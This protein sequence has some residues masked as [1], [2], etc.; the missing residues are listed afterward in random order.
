MSENVSRRSF[1]GLMGMGMMGAVAANTIMATQANASGGEALQLRDADSSAWDNILKNR[2]P[3]KDFA[4]Q[5]ELEDPSEYWGENVAAPHTTRESAYGNILP[6]MADVPRSDVLDMVLDE[7][8]LEEIEDVVL[9][10]GTVVPKVYVKLRNHINRIGSGIGSTPGPTSYQMLMY[11]WSEEDAQHEIEMPILTY[12]DANEYHHSSGRP[13][14]ECKEILEDMAN[15]NLIMKANHSGHMVYHLL[16]HINGFWEFNELRA[17]FQNGGNNKIPEGEDALKAA[18]MFDMQGIGGKDPG[19]SFNIEVP[20][21]HTYPVSV[22]VV[23]ED[24]L[25]PFMDW[26]R[27]IEENEKITVSPC[28]CRLMWASFGLPMCNG[29]DIAETEEGHPFETCLSFGELAEYFAETGIGR[30]ITQEEAIALYEEGMRR[31]MV[32]ESLSMKD[33]DIMCMCH[34]DCCGNLSGWK[35]QRGAGYSNININA[36]LLKY[37]P[38]KCIQCGACIERCPMQAISFD[39]DGYCLHN[40]TCVRCGQCV[41]VCPVDARI[42][43]YRGDFPEMGRDYVDAVETIAIDRMRRGMIKDFPGG[44]IE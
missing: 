2:D 27:I 10:D 22:D 7:L 30:Y 33:V 21:F 15:R 41:T 18:A 5:F 6:E 3:E 44:A 40:N 39:E 36:Y 24:E 14:D 29:V 16:P 23:E 20:L 9:P 25:A 42:L 12:F 13:L 28:Q 8:P 31:G 26:K 17:Y 38:D 19:S 4:L 43:K 35:A 37:F 32:P 11:L 34:G 1:V